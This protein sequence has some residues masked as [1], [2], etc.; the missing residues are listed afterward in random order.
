MKSGDHY[1]YTV[2]D[3]GQIYRLSSEGLDGISYIDDEVHGTGVTPV[4][5][6]VNFMDSDG[7]VVGEVEPYINVA[8]R[9]NKTEYDRDADPALQQLEDP[10]C[11]RT[12]RATPPRMTRLRS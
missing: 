10:H 5:R 3:E 7:R 2:M 8:K 12:L 11:H 6:D 1:L 9:L 4:V